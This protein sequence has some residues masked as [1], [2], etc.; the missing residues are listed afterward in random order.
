MVSPLVRVTVGGAVKMRVAVLP[1]SLAPVMAVSPAVPPPELARPEVSLYL[2]E[3]E[4][5]TA[6][7]VKFPL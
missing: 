3:V 7:T 4:V 6:V 2:N 5:G 1:L